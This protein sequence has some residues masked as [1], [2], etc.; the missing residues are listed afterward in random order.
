MAECIIPDSGGYNYSNTGYA[1]EDIEWHGLDD[2]K[3]NKFAKFYQNS[4]AN[5]GTREELNT[6]T[7]DQN[8][9]RF[10][11]LGI[12]EFQY[13][14]V[15][16]FNDKFQHYNET[17]HENNLKILNLN[18]RGIDRNYDNFTAYLSTL[19]Q[20]FHVIILSE[21]HITQDIL[22]VNIKNRYPLDGYNMFYVK[23]RI[24]YGGVMIYVKNELNSV[25]IEELTSSN[26]ICD[27]LYLK[28]ENG[29]T[30][31]ITG[32]YYRH[33]KPAK[34]DKLQY[35]NML[36][37][38]L[39]NK[40]LA[41]EKIILAGDFNICLMQSCHN[42]ES[43]LYLNT[44]IENKLECHIF[45]PTRI[46]HHKDSLQVKSMTLIDQIC[47]NFYENKCSSG[48]L[49]YD[50]SDHFPNFLI[51]ENVFKNNLKPSKKQYFRRNFIK[52]NDKELDKDFDDINWTGL[53]ANENNIETCFENIIEQTEILLDKHAPL[54]RISNRKAKHVIFKPW[55]DRKLVTEIKHKNSL[56]RKQKKLHNETNMT[57]YKIQ[58]N[59]VTKLLRSKK[60]KYFSEYFS[61][62]RQD[63]RKMWDGINL[64]LEQTRHKKTLPE[65]IYDTN[66]QPIT[67]SLHK[68]NCFAKHFKGVP[69]TAR[70]KIKTSNR[71]FTYYF[72]QMTPN[73]NYLV[74]HN[75]SP[76]E[77]KKHILQ[78]KNQS[79]SGPIQI[80]NVFLKKIAHK[81]TYPLTWAINKSLDSGYFPNILKLGKQTPVF[82]SGDYNVNN[83]R[84]ITVC[85]SFA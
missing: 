57:D 38:H 73:R 9:P 48:N 29:G 82:K 71:H 41:N 3:L 21:C 42:E 26:D 65:I 60:R 52:I 24:K 30:K 4:N 16:N 61:K 80:S 76:E 1:A 72:S 68:A 59:K 66:N 79:S 2:E 74:L 28:I 13:H 20:K 7:S 58:K 67:T 69:S 37:E 49:M 63:T 10:D 12:E 14:S 84:P 35:I 53:V 83:F 19:N 46:T 45:K 33:C 81:L 22:N 18:I 44:L 32:G 85:S 40:K 64:A 56:Y 47:S 5:I 70:K 27:S 75:C 8:F 23:S 78:L 39:K 54:T 6:L 31:F 55:I 15:E 62:Y 36:D 50:N 77:V 34:S 51:I 11:N 17:V 43:M 25:Y